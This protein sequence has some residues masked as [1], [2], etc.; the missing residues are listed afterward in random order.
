MSRI[1]FFY[2]KVMGRPKNTL[3][4]GFL[5]FEDIEM[6]DNGFLALISAKDQADLDQLYAITD[7]NRDG[8]LSKDE[9]IALA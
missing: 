3:T 6:R 2:D 5:L 4:G 1:M 7:I 8:N 9:I